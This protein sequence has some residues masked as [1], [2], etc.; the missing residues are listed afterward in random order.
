V[1]GVF[2][3]GPCV[4][5]ADLGHHTQGGERESTAKRGTMA[6]EVQTK[7]QRHQVTE[8]DFCPRFLFAPISE[9]DNKLNGYRD[10]G[11]LTHVHHMSDTRG[12]TE[13]FKFADRWGCGVYSLE[14]AY[15]PIRSRVPSKD[16][17]Y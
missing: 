11:T 10:N 2:L 5:L 16:K 6:A 14:E 13:G 8:G 1:C 17:L 15:A 7:M 9:S 3:D 4:T 12:T